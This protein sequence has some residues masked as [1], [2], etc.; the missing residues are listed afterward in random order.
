[1]PFRDGSIS[2]DAEHPVAIATFGIDSPYVARGGGARSIAAATVPSA[3]INPPKDVPIYFAAIESKTRINLP[4]PSMSPGCS[5]GT[6][7]A[8]SLKERMKSYQPVHSKRATR[9]C[10]PQFER[11]DKNID[12]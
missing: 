1:M 4:A 10:S 6:S 8:R 3:T 5:E 11:S 12:A 7:P 2:H 9:M